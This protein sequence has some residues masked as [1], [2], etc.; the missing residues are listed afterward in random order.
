[1]IWPRMNKKIELQ[2]IFRTQQ[3]ILYMLKSNLYGH[4]L[5]CYALYLAAAAAVAVWIKFNKFSLLKK[6]RKKTAERE[7]KR[8]N[9]GKCG[10]RIF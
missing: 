8:K 7:W 5:C 1:M 9:S 6:T 4:I 10:K 3:N 2:I